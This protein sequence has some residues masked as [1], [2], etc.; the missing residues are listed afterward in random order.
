VR[1]KLPGCDNA[2]F[3]HQHDRKRPRPE[4]GKVGSVKA[5]GSLVPPYDQSQ[6]TLISNIADMTLIWI[7]GYR[8]RGIGNIRSRPSQGRDALP[9]LRAWSTH[10]P[11]RS[12][13]NSRKISLFGQKRGANNTD[14]GM[15]SSQ[16]RQACL[17]GQVSQR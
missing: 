13:C 3:G 10:A 6:V 2:R 5:A 1:G 12:T 17:D 15:L 14:A 9:V 16:T 7:N 11:G 8:F 4:P